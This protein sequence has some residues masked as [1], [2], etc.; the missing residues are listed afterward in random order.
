MTRLPA[1]LLVYALLGTGCT[2]T[3]VSANGEPG[4]SN[5]CE[6]DADCEVGSCGAG[7]CQAANGQLEALLVSVSPPSDS[8]LPH[9][10]FV[11]HLAD[12]PTSGGRKD[13]EL[14]EAGRLAGTLVI[15]E[16]SCYPT[17]V[18]PDPDKPIF[19]AQDGRSLPVQVSLELRE[20][21]LGVPQ[22]TYVTRTVYDSEK[23]GAYSF[24]LQVPA[25]QYEMYLV[26]PQ[27]LSDCLIPP[28]LRR[29]WTIQG[30]EFAVAL[31]LAPISRLTFR[32]RWPKANDSLQG[33]RVDIIEPQGGKAISTV[34]TLGVPT[35]GPMTVE[36]VAQVAYSEVI[37]PEGTS[38]EETSGGDLLRLRPPD[39]V[40]APTIYLDRSALG[41]FGSDDVTLK[42]FTRLPRAVTVEGQVARADN[43]KPASGSVT[44]VS[45]SIAEVDQGIWASY[46]TGASIKD[47]VF[48]A[49]VPPGKY[50]VQVVPPLTGIPSTTP[51]EEAL[52]AYETTWDI[53]G[54]V[55]FQAGKLLEVPPL[56][57]LSG[58]SRV[59]GAQVQ[60]VATPTTNLPFEEAFGAGAFLPR[61]SSTLV[62]ASG[63]F[64]MLADPGKFDVTV[65]APDFLGFAWYVRP[66]L[67][68]ALARQDLGP[69]SLPSP[70][71]LSGTVSVGSD[72]SK[73]TVGSAVIRAYAYL[74]KQLAYT[75][76]PKQAVSVVQVAET[77]ADDSG[78]FRL[79][80]PSS[81]TAPK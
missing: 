56:N 69:V 33:W 63:H 35:D 10:T 73:L 7:V 3:A 39:G 49:D 21:L 55:A 72:M 31:P 76:D 4:V 38:V 22:Q 58:Q 26:P 30:G 16:R 64:Q 61:A 6:S 27:T 71:P 8:A 59:P 18:S 12:V 75:R 46:Q 67:E 62:D 14:D 57:T 66:G 2:V 23:T 9:F 25:G 47:G 32:L 77:R 17:F 52:A 37:E 5:T 78:A 51:G 74:D 40:V 1:A 44:L 60:A 20:R 81:I 28:Q 13:I 34:A 24:E 15:P 80:L 36:Y 79:L 11:T 41:L 65:Q 70:V 68:L 29:G 50:R 42:G 19:S 53:P 48:H 54:D 43:G 45:T